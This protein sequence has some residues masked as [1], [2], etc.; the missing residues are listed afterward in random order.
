MRPQQRYP[1]NFSGHPAAVIRCPG[2]L[3]AEGLPPASLQIVGERRAALQR[4]TAHLLQFRGRSIGATMLV[5]DDES[6]QPS[7]LFTATRRQVSSLFLC[8]N[9]IS[10]ASRH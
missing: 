1:L 10:G 2:A 9:Q 4:L 5:I 7:D 8:G 6:Y 3:T